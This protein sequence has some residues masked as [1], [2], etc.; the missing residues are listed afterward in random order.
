MTEN[1]KAPFKRWLT[2][3][4]IFA[5]LFGLVPLTAHSAD[6]KVNV[7]FNDEL[8]TFDAAKPVVKNGRTLVPFRKLFETLGFTVKWEEAARKAIGT[9]AGLTI[10]L[11]IDSATAKVN[12]KSVKLDVPAQILS[13]STMVPLR[14]VSEN[15][16]YVVSY[17]DEG[18]VLD[19]WV[20]EDKGQGER[21]PAN[22]NKVEPY[23]V[24]GRVVD[25]KGNPVAGAEVFADDQLLYDSNLVTYTDANGYYRIELTDFATTWNMGGSYDFEVEG[26]TFTVHLTPEVNQPFAGNTGAIRNMIADTDSVTGELF[27]YLWVDDYD[28]IYLENNIQLTLKPLNG[29]ETITRFGY[30]FP[31]GFGLNDLPVGSYEVSGQYVEAGE[32]P[33]PLYVRLKHTKEYKESTIFKFEP[34]VRGIYRAELEFWLDNLNPGPEPVRPF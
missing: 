13:K 24:K 9:K 30:N 33:I 1:K 16:G 11:T 8:I 12:G 5:L 23:V 4:S 18:G 6:K 7:Y 27:Y 14:F 3:L 22:A 21:P 31:G 34:L 15:S 19:I 17:D 32:E 20:D 25:S 29:G 2:A 28:K 26:D 10:E